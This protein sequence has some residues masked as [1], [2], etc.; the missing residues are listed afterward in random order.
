MKSTKACYFCAISVFLLL[1]L[2]AF[3]F[4]FAMF[5]G[6][7]KKVLSSAFRPSCYPS[8]FVV[9]FVFVFAMLVGNVRKVLSVFRPSCYPSVFGGKGPGRCRCRS[10]GY[11][12]DD[13]RV[14]FTNWLKTCQIWLAC[15]LTRAFYCL[16]IGW[17]K[18]QIVSNP[19][20]LSIWG[21]FVNSVAATKGY[22]LGELHG[23]SNEFG[24]MRLMIWGWW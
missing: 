20:S 13:M 2:C 5:V 18:C 15:Q 9:V 4:V 11:F 16:S 1:K 14:F 7:M 22:E 24:M 6:N 8:V 17:G 19:V 10:L 3:V 23:A 12:S 21:E